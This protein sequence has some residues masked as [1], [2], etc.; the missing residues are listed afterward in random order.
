MYASHRALCRGL[1]LRPGSRL[2]LIGTGNDTLLE[3]FW[4]Q[5][6]RRRAWDG[7]AALEPELATGCTFSVWEDYPRFDQ[8]HNQER[9]LWSYKRLLACGVPA[10]P[11]LFTAT[12]K[13]EAIAVEWLRRHPSVEVI[14]AL[15]QFWRTTTALESFL[16]QLGNLRDAVGRPLHFLLVGLATPEKISLAFRRLGSVTIAT[17]QPLMK[18]I[19]GVEILPDITYRSA[20]RYIPRERLAGI[21]LERFLRYCT[22]MAAKS[23]AGP[24]FQEAQGL[25]PQIDS[26]VSREDRSILEHRSQRGMYTNGSA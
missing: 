17:S 7:L 13:D 3:A 25:S 19:K 15:V 11:F 22:L 14:G 2:C 16:E 12:E 6:E 23:G 4:S 21:N 18:A 24:W 26:R 5:S 9:N 8:I 10:V 1:R 20:P